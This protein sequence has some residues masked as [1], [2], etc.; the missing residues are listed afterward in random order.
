MKQGFIILILLLY[1]CKEYAPV[2]IGEAGIEFTLKALM[3]EAMDNSHNNMDGV[4]ISI[5]STAK[6]I[7]WAGTLGYDSKEKNRELDIEQPFRIA[8]LT[9]TFV[10]ASI[11]RLHE[12]D[13]L[14]IEEPLSKYISLKHQ[15]ILSAD[16]YDLSKIKIFHCLNHTSGLYDYAMGG[17]PY[18]EVVR[19]DPKKKWTRTDQ[20]KFATEHG[21]PLGY[22]G[23]K[24]AYCDTGYILLGEIVEHFFDGDLAKGLRTLIN[25]EKLGMNRTWLESLE[26]PPPNLKPQVG[27]YLGKIDALQ[28][29]PSTDLYGGGGIVSTV[30]DLRKFMK[31]I[32]NHGI[33][34]KTS[35]LD[36]MLQKHHYDPT[37]DIY[38]DRRYKDY[39][40]GLWKITIMGK[41]VYMHSGLWGTHMLYQPESDTAVA[42]NFTKGGSDRLIKK[43]FM[44][45]N[46]SEK[47]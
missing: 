46:D 24:Y 12:M 8:S 9:K 36:M 1:S 25:Y 35:T 45:I 10:A 16:G 31:A 11:L 39:R 28:F 42:I 20:L 26:D 22:P 23:E 2:R 30:D 4:A 40:Q 17:S 33:Y 7:E 34:K 5:S 29:D 13:S 15:A 18:K 6:N 3:Q 37:Y 27:R 41:D 32:F 19:Q 38:K 47:Q 14:S 43:I 44:T 21:E